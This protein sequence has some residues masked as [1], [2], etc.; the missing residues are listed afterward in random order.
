MSYE[1]KKDREK[2]FL[3][4]VKS[5]YAKFPPGTVVAN[6]EPDF[7]V[8][9][10]EISCGIEIVQ[11]VRGQGKGGSP[12]RWREELHD[13]IVDS[14]QTKYQ[15]Q[16]GIALSVHL[17]WFH[18]RELRGSDIEWASDEICKLVSNQGSLEI[19]ETV[20][21]EPDYRAR[22]SDFITRIWVRRKHLGKN[23]WS[24]VEVGQ[25]EA[26]ALELQG[27]ITSMNVKVPTY[28]KKCGEVWLIIVADGQRISSSGEL[29][30]RER[31]TKFSSGFEKVLYYDAESES[32]IELLTLGDE[33]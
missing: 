10:G 13:Q 19:N 12:I 21:F 29:N 9:N 7:V 31:Q 17:H 14:A 2:R 27:V 3:E 6:E 26:D 33:S 16:S 18:H 4:E 15:A 22:I 20:T 11:Y 32:V 1:V 8:F 28:L 30:I 5:L 25:A 24:N 23:A